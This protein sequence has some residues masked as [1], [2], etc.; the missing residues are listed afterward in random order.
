VK[1]ACVGGGPAGLYLSM[2]MKLRDPEHDVVVFERNENNSASGWG[3]T[4][5]QGLLRRLYDQDPDSAREI[6]AAA[7][8]WSDQVTHIHGEQ[9]VA[10]GSN[11]CNITRRRLL[12]I[13][14]N[15]ALELGVRVEYGHEIA[16]VAELPEVGVVIASD[17]IN[18]RI[19]QEAGDF[20][21]HD[22]SGSNKYIWLGT[23]KVF[24]Q[25]NF[26]FVPTESGWVWAHAYG[27]D[28]AS[29]TFIVECAPETWYG[30]GFAAMSTYEALPI[31]ERIFKEHL[32]G[33]RL[34][35]DLGDGTRARWL[36][37]RTISNLRWHSG[38]VVLAG[39]SAHTAHFAIGMG[40]TLAIEDAIVLADSLHEHSNTELA[41]QSYEQQRKAEMLTTLTE[42]RWS[43]R[44]FENLPRYIDRKPHQFSAL[45]HARRSPLIALL[46]PIVS[47]LLCTG[48]DRM[49][50]LDGV[51][52][53]VGPTVK[54]IYGR[55]KPTLS[56]WDAS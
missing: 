55:R 20:Q 42:A 26:L 40:T 15:R 9:L 28:S 50:F 14:G 33:S 35:G 30:L 47:C 22:V 39:D 24:E 2:L 10:P 27:I 49:T 1:I 41:F 6:E 51:R 37:F 44:W 21:T 16:S 13:L 53:W 25:F 36:N 17:G 12:D 54:R 29:S 19:R 5:G 7:F 52:H 45:I 23:D 46:P 32:S 48:A 43:A 8:L 11:A 34:I 31:L 38:K 4:F 56:Q 3:V 18:S